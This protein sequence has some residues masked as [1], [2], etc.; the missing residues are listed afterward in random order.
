MNEKSKKEISGLAKEAKV[1]QAELKRR[2]IQDLRERK[3]QR[4]D[5]E[6]Y[7]D[8]LYEQYGNQVVPY[9]KRI[10]E[11]ISLAEAKQVFFK[12]VLPSLNESV[13]IENSRLPE[14]MY[15]TPEERAKAI[16]GKAFYRQSVMDRM[17]KGWK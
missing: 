13:A 12:E 11:A 2:N 7:Y 8:D 14:T 10:T 4:T 16:N 3:A 9:K 5:C 17:P 1:A 15:T 6:V